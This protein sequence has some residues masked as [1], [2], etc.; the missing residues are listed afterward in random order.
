[1]ASYSK[2]TGSDSEAF[3]LRSV[4]SITSS[5]QPESSRIVY[6][7]SDFPHPILPKKARIILCKI[8]PDPIWMACS[9]PEA[10]GV[11]E[12]SGRFPA[13]CNRRATNFPFSAS[14]VFFHRRPESCCGKQALVR[15]GFGQTDP[16]W[17]HAGGLEQ[18]GP[19][20]ANAFEPI[21]IICESDPVR[22]IRIRTLTVILVS[23]PACLLVASVSSFRGRVPCIV[24]KTEM[25]FPDPKMKTGK[26]P[27]W[28]AL[29]TGRAY[30][31]TVR[32][33]D[34]SANRV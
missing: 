32:L 8:G 29:T 30:G 17:R 5:V 28:S 20:L 33:M 9:A 31:T 23:D 12:S 6:A 14:V 4:M 3:W 10:S 2:H 11:Q 22:I 25:Q 26:W 24:C 34:S 16:V 13:E 18:S 15:F 1:M 19:F 7:R 27:L 21:L